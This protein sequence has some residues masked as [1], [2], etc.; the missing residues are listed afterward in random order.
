MRAFS[1]IFLVFSITARVGAQSSGYPPEQENAL[2]RTRP[3]KQL[4]RED[5]PRGAYLWKS[6][7]AGRSGAVTLYYFY[8]STE[9][10]KGKL[11]MYRQADYRVRVDARKDPPTAQVIKDST[12]NL[13]EVRIRMT[14]AGFSAARACF[15]V[16]YAAVPPTAMILPDA[17]FRQAHLWTCRRLL[18]P[19]AGA[20]A[21]SHRD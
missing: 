19:A 21:L 10:G 3:G 14:A 2:Q 9:Y 8:G 11:G 13:K 17:A 5:E 4:F 12:G 7:K 1:L 6:L 15:P 18:R 16:Q 20:S